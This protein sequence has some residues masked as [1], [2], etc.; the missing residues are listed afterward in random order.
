MFRQ[1]GSGVATGRSS[2][3]DGIQ[4]VAP[5]W[6]KDGR[7]RRQ[8]GTRC[9]D[10]VVGVESAPEVGPSDGLPTYRTREASEENK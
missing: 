4:R 7:I 8:D 2:K 10:N 6:P 9:A 5:I 3:T 1:A